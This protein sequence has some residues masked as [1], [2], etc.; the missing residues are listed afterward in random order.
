MVARCLRRAAHD[1]ID[2]WVDDDLAFVVPWGFDL[3]AVA[4][5]VALWQGR[6]DAMVPFAH[7]EWLAGHLAG[8]RPRLFDDEG[9]LSLVNGRL[10]DVLDDLLALGTVRR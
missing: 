10:D 1:G 3:A 6:H 7:G 8:A 2:G 5:P 4:R 9:H